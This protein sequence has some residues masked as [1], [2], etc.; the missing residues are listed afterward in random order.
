MKLKA[1]QISNMDKHKMNEFSNILKKR[2]IQTSK[3]YYDSL[4]NKD[5]YQKYISKIHVPNLE[6]IKIELNVP[7]KSFLEVLSSKKKNKRIEKEKLSESL[8]NEKIKKI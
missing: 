4:I 3:L 6:E 8:Y 5:K 2:Y 7:K 1:E